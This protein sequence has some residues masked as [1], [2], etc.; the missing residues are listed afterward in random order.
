MRTRELC[1]RAART[2]K[3]RAGGWMVLTA[4]MVLS[5]AG[6][7]AA[8][9]A[10]LSPEMRAMVQRLAQRDPIQ[11]CAADTPTMLPS[12][13]F[14]APGGGAIGGGADPNVVGGPTGLW[15]QC[16]LPFSNGKPGGDCEGKH[17]INWTVIN[18]DAQAKVTAELLALDTQ[19]NVLK[20]F[21]VKKGENVQLNSRLSPSDWKF[22]SNKGTYDIFAPVGMLRVKV[23]EPNG[24]SAEAYCTAIP[25]V[26]VI[27][28]D[29]GVV[30]DNSGGKIDFKAAV[31][32]TNLS[33]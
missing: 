2:L 12:P 29:G 15:V 14:A 5:I 23:T 19:G 20:S 25:F 27:K 21:L 30:T 17:N 32:R 33:S 18:G 28:P 6:T 8:G 22:T 16:S 9:P 7:A 13:M 4:M 1:R 26:D 11:S 31:P 3:C 24:D 10:D